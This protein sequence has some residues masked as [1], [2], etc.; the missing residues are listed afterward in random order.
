MLAARF[1]VVECVCVCVC[2]CEGNG[3]EMKKE[4]EREDGESGKGGLEELSG[5]ISNS[6][7]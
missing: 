2:V 4:E 5:S 7:T 6:V 3:E 1:Q